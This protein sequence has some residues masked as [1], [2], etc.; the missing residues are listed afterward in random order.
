MQD[1]NEMRPVEK[2]K[3]KAG[4]NTRKKAE[5]NNAICPNCGYEVGFIWIHGHYQ[6]PVCKA[7]IISC[8]EGEGN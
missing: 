6:C 7:V 8:C 3:I 1:S 4:R 5:E 2:Q